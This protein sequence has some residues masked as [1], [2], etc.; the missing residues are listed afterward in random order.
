MPVDAVATSHL[1]SATATTPPDRSPTFPAPRAHVRP[2]IPY[3]PGLGHQD[4]LSP[5]GEPLDAEAFTFSRQP[6]LHELDRHH[7]TQP[8]GNWDTPGLTER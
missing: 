1:R 5:T 4:A 7:A 6:Q 8:L 3:Y 2:P